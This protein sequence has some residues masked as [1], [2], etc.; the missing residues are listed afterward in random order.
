[1]AVQTAY[2]NNQPAG[3]AGQKATGIKATVLSGT[4]T[5]AT[6]I[7]FGAPVSRGT[8]ERSAVPYAAAN[9]FWGIALLDRGAVP[10]EPASNE[11]RT[12]QSARILT[13]GDVWVHAGVAVN[14]GQS[15]F[16]TPAGVLTNT[17]S[18]GTNAAIA[19]ATWELTIGAAGL[20]IIRIK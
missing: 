8:A 3:V 2:P 5:G 20:S 7:A 4:V 16:V 9:G 6:A 19:G 1:M 10:T 17:D 18:G 13:E 11:Y 12:G 14:Q 15:V